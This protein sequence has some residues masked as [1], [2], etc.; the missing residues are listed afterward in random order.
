[1]MEA[2]QGAFGDAAFM[3][4]V[5]DDIRLHGEPSSSLEFSTE[6]LGRLSGDGLAIPF[7]RDRRDLA[8][9]ERAAE[10]F[11]RLGSSSGWGVRFGRELNATD[12]RGLFGAARGL[13]VVDGRQ[14]GPFIVRTDDA[15]RFVSRGDAS[16]RLG[17]RWRRH[18]LAYRDVASSTNRLTL[19]AG[20]LPPD[21]V[22][23]HTVFCLR[24]PLPL[25]AQYFL[26]GLF[27]SFVVNYLVRMR[28]TTHVTTEIVEGLPL[29]RRLDAPSAFREIAASTRQLVR[30]SLK[31]RASVLAR[32]NARVA[33][34]FQ[35]SRDEFAHV[36]G[37]FPL[38]PRE[39]RDRALAAHKTLL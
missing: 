24:T 13:P 28:V 20:L 1:M 38:I 17:D 39:E 12:D 25:A 23:T 35:L 27:N 33:V 14:I 26:C 4:A 8:I 29:P 36:V 19:I 31:D 30:G 16:R 37:T 6:L 3:M 18:R 34:L 10:L 7:V 32:L 22:S 15:T 5:L 9:A 21:S 2:G 11:P